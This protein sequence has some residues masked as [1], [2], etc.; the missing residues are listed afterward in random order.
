[1]TPRVTPIDVRVL[2][3]ID[4][5]MT[6]EEMT[7]ALGRRARSAVYARVQKLASMGLVEVVPNKARMRRLTERGRQLLDREPADPS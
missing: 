1:M 2:G 3:F 6:Y 7:R 4:Q 5:G